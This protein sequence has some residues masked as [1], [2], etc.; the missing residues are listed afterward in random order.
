MNRF[1]AIVISV[2][3][4][5]GVIACSQEPM[6][7]PTTESTTVDTI[8]T[9]PKLPSESNARIPEGQRLDKK[10]I[11]NNSELATEEYG[12]FTWLDF[13]ELHGEFDEK[14]WEE[15]NGDVIA[16][17]PPLN[18]PA[19]GLAYYASVAGFLDDSKNQTAPFTCYYLGQALADVKLRL[20]HQGLG[21]TDTV[22]NIQI[23]YTAPPS[24]WQ[25]KTDYGLD[26]GYESQ[27]ELVADQWR[28]CVRSGLV[29]TSSEFPIPS[30]Q[31]SNLDVCGIWAMAVDQSNDR[32]ELNLKLPM[33][34]EMESDLMALNALCQGWAMPYDRTP[35][36]TIYNP[37][38]GGATE[39]TPIVRP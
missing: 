37:V 28:F 38:P 32:R 2:V 20:D 34:P 4:V 1:A 11:E 5:L 22:G 10:W 26:M 14:K 17:I 9:T 3:A 36:T 29:F 8:A 16:T 39:F 35:V 19:A 24:F 7:E 21:V 27:Q 25:G 31:Q 12:W 6:Q 23:N 15:F 33:R 30:I 18:D 13:H